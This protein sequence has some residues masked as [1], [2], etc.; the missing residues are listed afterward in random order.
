MNTQPPQAGPRGRRRAGFFLPR[1]LP[2]PA[3]LKKVRAE[4]LIL[5]WTILTT[6][7]LV[8][9]TWPSIGIVAAL[10][11]VGTLLVRAPASTIPIPPSW[12][13]S[14]LIGGLIGAALGGGLWYFIRLTALG[15][16][17]VWGTSL[18]LWTSSTTRIAQG[19][20]TLIRPLGRIGA[21]VDEWSRVMNLALR[22]LPV[23]SD[24]AQAV[25]DTAKLRMGSEWTRATPGALVRLGVDI[26]TACLSAASRSARDTGRAMSMRGG[27]EPLD[28]RRE[29]FTPADL[30]AALAGIC[31]IVGIVAVRVFW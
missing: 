8:W 25:I 17:I 7:L 19:L 12:F 18:L 10:L 5:A 20:R 31:A 27:F 1:A 4:I 24:Q 26:T 3:P 29:R 6:L 23:V 13:W 16:V 14:G 15:L 22:A 28:D 2:G 21:P 11:T 30:G 9:P